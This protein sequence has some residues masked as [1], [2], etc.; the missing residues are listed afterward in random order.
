MKIL[1]F[2]ASGFLGRSLLP[3]L[4]EDT[5]IKSI[6]AITHET[7]LNIQSE[8]KLSVISVNDFFAVGSKA[9]QL[10][11]DTVI[12]LA[13]RTYSQT[14]DERIIKESNLD[15]PKRIVD[16]CI[17]VGTDHFILASSINVRLLNRHNRGYPLYKKSAEDYVAGSCLPYTILRPS[18]IFG[19]N[20]AGFSRLV[21]HIK[22]HRLMPVFGDGRKLEQPIHVNEA[23]AFFHQAAV[24]PA[25]C[26]AVEIGGLE[27]MTY[28]DML[29]KIAAA[30]KRKIMLLHIPARPLCILMEFLE[31]RGLGL[32]VN[33]EQIAHIDT[34]LDI[35]NA[36]ALRRYNVSLQ[37]FDKL[38]AAMDL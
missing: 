18:L 17:R 1:I 31:R 21:R 38:L 25:A 22:K 19:P 13:G 7:P 34:D 16:M 37:P 14:S 5:Y 8:E 23:A 29:L 35:D 26:A 36:S 24:S 9:A 2:G 20:D 3:R 27:A 32:P 6:T 12:C 4:L 15:M 11:Y 30:L 10:R 33:S 28:D